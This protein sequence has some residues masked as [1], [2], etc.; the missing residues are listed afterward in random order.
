MKG[1]TVCG[2][3]NL[4]A[5]AESVG[6]HQ[7]V[8]RSLA[9]GGEEF[10]F[11]DGGGDVVLFGFKSERAGHAAA[12]GSWRLEINADAGEDCLF[13]VHFEDGLVV[14]MAV[15]DGLA[16]QS[17]ERDQFAVAV[18]KFTEE[19]G[20]PRE[21]LGALVPGEEIAEFVAEDSDAAGFEADDGNAGFD[22]GCERVEDAEEQVFSAIEHAEIVKGASAAEIAGGQFH[23]EAGV[24]ED[25]DG[26]LRRIGEEVV[27]ERVWPEHNHRAV[28]MARSMAA[29]PALERPRREWRDAALLR[30]AGDG[31]GYVA[32]ERRLRGHVDQT[33]SIR[34]EARPEIDVAEGVMVQRAQAALVIVR[35][36]L[37]F[38]GG[39]IDRHRAIRLARFAGVAE[40][41]GFFDV[42]ALPTVADDIAL[43][44]LP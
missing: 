12:A 32:Q 1:V 5:A 4:L 10:E 41:R 40:V 20:L 21:T 29:E 22:L 17:G 34:G 24:L 26:G 18:E 23:A 44:H 37:G 8:W 2:L 19:D 7:P 15:D 42:F 35:E 33:R 31:L 30:D 3:A 28:G 27:V 36:K 25:V 38:I 14:T 39:E 13:G 16:L 9:D 6:D 43:R 11:A